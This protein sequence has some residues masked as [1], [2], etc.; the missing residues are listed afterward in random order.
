MAGCRERERGAAADVV[1]PERDEWIDMCL[2]DRV[3]V[4][5][6]RPVRVA[7]LAL[8][9][10]TF[11]GSP[12]PVEAQEPMGVAAQ[13]IQDLETMKSKFV[14]LARA[15]EAD[16]MDWRPMEGTRSVKDV[17]GLMVAEVHL[18]PAMCGF[19]PPARAA[20]GFGPEMERVAALSAD[21][22]IDEMESG[23]DFMIASVSSLDHDRLHAPSDWFGTS[24]VL[25]A[26]IAS[27]LGDMHE[28]LGQLIAYARTNRIVPPWSR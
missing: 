7:G 17:I 19:D 23:F 4:P 26:A 3:P 14:S 22:A 10:A 21:A 1:P 5:S 12:V 13:Q 20:D 16:Q 24:M 15:F 8:T 27:A 2:F 6:V 11:A 18:F 9:L 28:H 25:E